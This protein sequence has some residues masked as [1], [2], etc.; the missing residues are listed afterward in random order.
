MNPTTSLIS[1]ALAVILSGCSV[2][3]K[4]HSEGDISMEPST[5]D[6]EYVIAQE[7][8]TDRYPS[9][10]FA[11]S[12]PDGEGLVVVDTVSYFM[13]DNCFYV[14]RQC[15]SIYIVFAKDSDNS[16]NG[17]DFLSFDWYQK[18]DE[19]G[20]YK[21]EVK[22]FPYYW[23]EDSHVGAIILKAYFNG[24]PDNSGDRIADA[25]LY[26]ST[27]DIYR[28]KDRNVL[29]VELVKFVNCLKHYNQ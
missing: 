5:S 1:G 27:N 10:V 6:T 29:D 28:S 25:Y 3:M 22:D 23:P 12:N 20:W 18:P 16:L 14:N 11:Y 17:G 26:N 8:T 13:K 19:N 7:K 24:E 2:S 4:S 9:Q 21:V 15:R